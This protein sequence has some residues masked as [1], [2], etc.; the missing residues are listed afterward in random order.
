MGVFQAMPFSNEL[1]CWCSV[2]LCLLFCNDYI[3]SSF[4]QGRNPFFLEPA[5]IVAI[6]DGS[7]LTSSS[8]VQDEVG[9]LSVWARL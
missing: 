6:T 7:K 4:L 3:V 2:F 9:Y 5:I 1:H 8:G